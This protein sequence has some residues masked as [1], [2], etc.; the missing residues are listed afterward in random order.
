VAPSGAGVM[1]SIRQI[2]FPT[3]LSEPA[4]YA[5]SYALTFARKVGAEVRLLHVVAPLPRLTEPHA[6]RFH[7]EMMAQSLAAQAIACMNRQVEGAKTHG[8]IVHCEVRVGTDYRVIIQY[9]AKHDID[10]IVMATHGRTGLAHALLGSVAAKVVR[11]APCP[12][13]TIKYPSFRVQDSLEP[14]G[15]STG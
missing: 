15:R 13:L 3:D 9:A 8:V 12:V 7:P 11:M 6:M 4:G 10:L 2:L 5:W 14:C 1:L